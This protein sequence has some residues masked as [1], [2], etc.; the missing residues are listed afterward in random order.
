ML[1]DSD[2]EYLK[3]IFSTEFYWST[4]LKKI[5]FHNYQTGDLTYKNYLPSLNFTK[6][7]LTCSP[8]C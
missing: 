5:K 6:L 7:Y 4:I 8:N 2:L 3:E 1:H